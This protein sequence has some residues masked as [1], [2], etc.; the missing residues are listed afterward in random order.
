VSGNLVWVC[1]SAKI[2]SLIVG[3]YLISYMKRNLK[4][5][6]SGSESASR[7]VILPGYQSLLLLLMCGLLIEI[8]NLVLGYFNILNTTNIF[9][10]CIYEWIRDG[11]PLIFLQKSLS[12]KAFQRAFLYSLLWAGH[13]IMCGCFY[14]LLDHKSIFFYYG[15]AAIFYVVVLS[16]CCFQYRHP[17][18]P[19]LVMMLVL[20]VVWIVYY[21]MDMNMFAPLSVMYWILISIIALL[22]IP[23]LFAWYLVLL[24]DTRYWRQGCV[25]SSSSS[26]STA[27]AGASDR[28]GLL[29][30]TKDEVYNIMW[31]FF[32]F[33]NVCL[34]IYIS[35]CICVSLFM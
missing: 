13:G 24:T 26:S 28:V 34:N 6:R 15:T 16:R 17:V 27:F 30:G 31:L 7:S 11:F 23:L 25:S 29:E 35:E 19:Y 33:V 8:G 5:A 2:V 10:W 1:G 3:A 9:S 20:R 12:E 22:E 14:V 4:L 32:V 21:L 18:R